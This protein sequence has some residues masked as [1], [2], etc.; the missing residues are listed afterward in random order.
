MSAKI[1]QLAMR[2]EQAK[3]PKYRVGAQNLLWQAFLNFRGLVYEKI[4]P[5]E[6]EIK[7]NYPDLFAKLSVLEEQLIF[8]LE[9]RS[10]LAIMK[11]IGGWMEVMGEVVDRIEKQ[12]VA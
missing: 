8:D 5:N 12:R 9:P 3:K 6:E 10:D 11:D 1:Y 4:D 2:K 7:V